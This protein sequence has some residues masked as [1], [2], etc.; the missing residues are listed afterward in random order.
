MAYNI[1]DNINPYFFSCHKKDDF[2]SQGGQPS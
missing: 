2:T 1:I